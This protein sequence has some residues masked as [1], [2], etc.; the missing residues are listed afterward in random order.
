MA[1]LHSF[2]NRRHRIPRL[3]RNSLTSRSHRPKM[4]AMSAAETRDHLIEALEADLV[5]PFGR[6]PGEEVSAAQE[7]LKLAPSRFYLTGFLA[8]KRQGV[9]DAEDAADDDDELPA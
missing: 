3:R 7:A 9:I 6:E 5:G 1:A 8:P 2:S 4:A